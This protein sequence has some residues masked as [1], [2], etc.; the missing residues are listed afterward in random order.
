LLTLDP[1]PV[2]IERSSAL[3]N[4]ERHPPEE[5]VRFAVTL[6]IIGY[7]LAGTSIGLGMLAVRTYPAERTWVDRFESWRDEQARKPFTARFDCGWQV[8]ICTELPQLTGPLADRAVSLLPAHDAIQC[9]EPWWSERSGDSYCFWPIEGSP[10]ADSTITVQMR[11]GGEVFAISVHLP[12][13]RS[14]DWAKTLSDSLRATFGTPLACGPEWDDEGG[15]T[16][17]RTP[18]GYQVIL[19]EGSAS[20]SIGYFLSPA[21][22]E[23]DQTRYEPAAPRS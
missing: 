9:M 4:V 1:H 21:P 20:V 2:V 17:W 7:S 19:E 10:R 3:I 22:C 8:I 11:A 18:H 16:R 14:E 13:A 6:R 23:S 12:H 5:S 15:I